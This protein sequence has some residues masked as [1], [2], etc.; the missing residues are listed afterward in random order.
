MNSMFARVAEGLGRQYDDHR[1]QP[2][3]AALDDVFG[4]LG[5]KLDIALK[6]RRDQPI[7]G[8]HVVA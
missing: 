7:D 3:A 8:S 5:D 4:H 1:A 2:L 6:A